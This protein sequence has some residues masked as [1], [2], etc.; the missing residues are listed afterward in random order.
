[1]MSL[2]VCPEQAQGASLKRAQ[3]SQ[4]TAGKLAEM[5]ND[6]AE[7]YCGPKLSWRLVSF[8]GST[9]INSNTNTNTNINIDTNTN[10]NINVNITTH[11]NINTHI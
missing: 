2:R 3:K 9:N 1:M 11:M 4:R 5:K 10:I 6:P 8:C 7:N